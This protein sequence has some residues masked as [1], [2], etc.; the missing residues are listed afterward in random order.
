MAMAMYCKQQLRSD[1]V[2]DMPASFPSWEGVVVPAMPEVKFPI[3]VD[4]QQYDVTVPP[5]ASISTAAE[6]F[7]SEL[8]VTDGCREGIEWKIREHRLLD[9]TLYQRMYVRSVSDACMQPGRKPDSPPNA[10][11]CSTFIGNG[12]GQQQFDTASDVLVHVHVP[13]T[14]GSTFDM[15][16]VHLKGTNCRKITAT[17]FHCSKTSSNG[18]TDGLIGAQWLLSRFTGQFLFCGVHASLQRLATCIPLLLSVMPVVGRPL[19]SLEQTLNSE[20]ATLRQRHLHYITFLRN[21]VDRFLSEFNSHYC[22]FPSDFANYASDSVH[23][24]VPSSFY[25][26]GTL[27][28][29]SFVDCSTQLSANKASRLA[30]PKAENNV[31]N[32]TAETKPDMLPTLPNFLWCRPNAAIN[33]QVR[34]LGD[35]Q[36]VDDEDGRTDG[37]ATGSATGSAN[38]SGAIRR[39]RGRQMLESAKRNLERI[40]YFGLLEQRVQSECLFEWTFGLHFPDDVSATDDVAHVR[41]HGSTS[42]TKSGGAKHRVSR[43]DLTALELEMVA[44]ANDLD[45]QLYEHAAKVFAERLAICGVCGAIG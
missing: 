6:T 8:N 43:G 21:P 12:F 1:D 28:K 27:R 10:E 11:E 33:R 39:E 40:S 16:L 37:S 26:N 17:E 36:C 34:M 5:T 30:H 7:C 22:G 45:V 19:P 13:R 25:C 24:H 42:R 32:A 2:E 3:Q 15:Q 23:T 38:D 20:A 31:Q 9:W 18:G 14:G 35:S 44:Q 4:S 41:W 29:R